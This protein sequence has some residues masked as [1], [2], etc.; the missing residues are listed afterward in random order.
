M[1]MFRSQPTR[2]Q[3]IG[4]VIVNNIE[5]KTREEFSKFIQGS[6]AGIKVDEKCLSL[7]VSFKEI[8]NEVRKHH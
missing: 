2:L 7:G 3:L 5:V 4:N 8:W 1:A 6:P